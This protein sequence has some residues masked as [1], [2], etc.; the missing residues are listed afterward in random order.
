MIKI[1]DLR[2]VLE[3]IV[4]GLIFFG[5][6]EAIF[7]MLEKADEGFQ[8]CLCELYGFFLFSS[9][10]LAA[11]APGLNF[12]KANFFLVFSVFLAIETLTTIRLLNKTQ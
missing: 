9:V 12:E 5:L 6:H 8:Y 3:V 2:P 11:A 1:K 7:Y 10:I 4:L